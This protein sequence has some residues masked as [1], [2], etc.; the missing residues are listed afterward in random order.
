MERKYYLDLLRIIAIVLVVFNHTPGFHSFMIGAGLLHSQPLAILV[1]VLTKVNVPIFV[2][3]SGTLL[4]ERE[5]S[6]R[7]LWKKRISRFL[8]VILIFTTLRYVVY[9]LTKDYPTSVADLARGIFS[10]QLKGFDSY[11]FLYAYL[12]FLLVLPFLRLI[13]KGLTRKHFYML[14][15][16]HIVMTSCIPMINFCLSMIGKEGIVISSMMNTQ[17]YTAKLMFYP[18]MGYYIDRKIDISSLTRKHWNMLFGASLIG[19]IVSIAATYLYGERFGYDV[20]FISSFTYI[21][22]ITIFLLVKRVYT[23]IPT[24]KII[25]KTNG[26][27]LYVSSLTFGIYLL[28]NIVKAVIW[29]QISEATLPVLGTYG[30]SVLWCL[31]S[32]VICGL[33]TAGLK[34]IPFVKKLV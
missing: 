21:F 19:L 33:I 34:K 7:D 20:N 6:F 25:T 13:A 26:I 30:A 3:I 1:A 8:L 24:S 31:I 5:E 32:F 15:L 12:S 10:G 29:K 18:I 16:L 4:L 11:W 28:D 14:M 27:V 23:T 9:G 22:A 2:M 17:L